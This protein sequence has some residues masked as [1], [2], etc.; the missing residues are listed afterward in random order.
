MHDP[1]QTMRLHPGTSARATGKRHMPSA[2]VSKPVE[3]KLGL[4]VSIFA[5]MHRVPTGNDASMED[6]EIKIP[7]D[8]H[9]R[10]Q[11]Y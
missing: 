10:I 3:H 7:G 4:L 5:T 2:E 9:L 11:P 1:S 8:K 6:R